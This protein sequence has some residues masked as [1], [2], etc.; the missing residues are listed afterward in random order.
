MAEPTQPPPASTEQ[1]VKTLRWC[2]WHKDVAD[3]TLLIGA[4]ER[5]SAGPRTFYACGACREEHRLIPL[6]ERV[7]SGDV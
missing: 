1:D 7:A 6:A 2:H 3:D 4:A 5:T